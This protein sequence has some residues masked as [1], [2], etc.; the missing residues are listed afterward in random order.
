MLLLRNHFFRRVIIAY[1][2]PNSQW[3]S[4]KIKQYISKSKKNNKEGFQERPENKTVL[5][6]NLVSP[7]DSLMNVGLLFRFGLVPGSVLYPTLYSV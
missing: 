3:A 6:M 2:L 4:P 7:R 1:I 5:S